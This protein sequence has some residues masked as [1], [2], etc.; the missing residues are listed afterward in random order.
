[1]HLMFWLE[2]LENKSLTPLAG[3][4]NW[5]RSR[6]K[7]SES[8]GLAGNIS[9]FPAEIPSRGADMRCGNSSRAVR[10]DVGAC[11]AVAALLGEMW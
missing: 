11:A 4:S 3:S 8:C 5:W 6:S 7:R 9:D 10:W 2:A 1:M